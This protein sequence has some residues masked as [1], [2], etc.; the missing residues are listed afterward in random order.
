MTVKSPAYGPPSQGMDNERDQMESRT[1]VGED[2]L[3]FDPPETR[4]GG[5]HF[6]RMWNL[7]L[8]VRYRLTHEALVDA[9]ALS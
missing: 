3:W 2:L 8:L 5:Y 9:N 1:A 6:F 4:R 7:R